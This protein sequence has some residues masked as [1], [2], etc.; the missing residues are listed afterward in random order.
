MVVFFSSLSFGCLFVIEAPIETNSL[1]NF[2]HHHPLF[3]FIFCER[4]GFSEGVVCFET[5]N[6]TR[7]TVDPLW[8][9]CV[10]LSVSFFAVE[11]SQLG[12]CDVELFRVL[13]LVSS[14]ESLRSN[15]NPSGE[16]GISSS[17]RKREREKERERKSKVNESLRRNATVD[18][19]WVA[20][21]T[22]CFLSK[23]TWST[24][25]KHNWI[26]FITLDNRE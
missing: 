25:E 7:V 6:I 1:L 10:C 16:L 15:V 9:Q 4:K 8:I 18:S 14:P 5:H 11:S 22:N 3:D 23:W 12:D 20:S 19:K 2:M 21:W 26:Y 24:Q 13:F 17:H